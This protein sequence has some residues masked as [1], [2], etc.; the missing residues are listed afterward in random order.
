MVIDIDF[1]LAINN[2][3][4]KY[5]LGLDIIEALGKRVNSVR[6]S[7]L[8]TNFSNDLLRRIH[9]RLYHWENQLRISDLSVAQ[10]LPLQKANYPT[11]HLDPLTALNYELKA[12]DIILCHDVGP[13]SHPEYFTP[14]TESFYK[15]AYNKIQES[16]CHL[17]FV[18]DTTKREFVELY[19][20]EFSSLSVIHIP[21]R[22]DFAD[23]ASTVYTEE[24]YFLTTGSLGNRK[25]QLASIKAFEQSGLY[26][27]GYQY[28][29]AGPEEPGSERVYEQA[30]VTDGVTILGYVSDQELKRLYQNA[31]GFV[32]MSFLE[33]FGM[34]IVE[35]ASFGLPCLVSKGGIFEEV[36]GPSMFTADPCDTDAIAQGLI[37]M[38]QLTVDERKERHS[39][40]ISHIDQFQP[41]KLLCKWPELIDRCVTSLGSMK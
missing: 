7:R 6:F 12:Q 14:E 38:S 35:A 18:S 19:G 4:G 9:G 30:S 16:K 13:V 25:N 37:H 29:L 39:L 33:G 17:V 1:S 23:K 8:Q 24:K 22:K 36:G 15:K 32:L 41:D 3:T 21:I 2:R 20:D 5:Y 11:L 10:L 27:Q 40:A 26:Q 28:F 34:P 31:T